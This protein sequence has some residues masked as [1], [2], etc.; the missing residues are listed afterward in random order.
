[1]SKSRRIEFLISC[2]VLSIEEIFE[3][4]ITTRFIV[5]A[6]TMTLFIGTMWYLVR[7][8]D[9]DTQ[10]KSKRPMHFAMYKLFFAALNGTIGGHN[11]LFAK[12]TVEIFAQGKAKAFTYGLFY[13]TFGLMIGTVLTQVKWLNEG[14]RRFDAV[15]MVPV[16]TA[17]WVF[18]SAF[19][20]IITFAE[21]SIMSW[22]EILY[23]FIGIVLILVGVLIFAQAKTASRRSAGK[24][25]P[26]RGKLNVNSPLN[27]QDEDTS[28][29]EMSYSNRRASNHKIDLEHSVSQ[30]KN[31]QTL[32]PRRQSIK[33]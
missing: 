2:F 33:N 25:S 3:L 18:F 16:S 20:G 6:I 12:L 26:S 14:L 27:R 28:N 21:Y 32:S 23:F 22:F 24:R 31:Y 30:N 13:I 19:S 10:L 17:F 11:V 4:Y 8:W 1:M 29:E 15:F 7:R 9:K 5:Y